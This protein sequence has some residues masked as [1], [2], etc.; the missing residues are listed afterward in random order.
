VPVKRC[1]ANS[2]GGIDGT[3]KGSKV[4][5]IAT[6]CSRGT[7]LID[8]NDYPC[9]VTYFKTIGLGGAG[10][11]VPTPDQEVGLCDTSNSGCTE[12]IDPVSQFSAN[13]VYNPGYQLIDN[14]Y[15]GWTGSK[16]EI[17]LE[18]NKL[19]IFGTESDNGSNTGEVKLTPSSGVK[20]LLNNN[21]LGTSTP[22]LAISTGANRH[23]LFASLGN[24][25]ATL[26][27]GASGKTIIVKEAVVDYQLASN[28]DKTS[29]NGLV[30]F[31]NGCILFN[32]RKVNGSEGLVS[33]TSG[34]DAYATLDG[35]APSL[36]NSGAPDSCNA[37]KLIKVRPNRVC[38]KWLDCLTY[39]QDPTTNEKTC[40]AVGE[41]N[42]LNDKN[43]CANFMDTVGASSTR[44]FDA[45]RDKDATGYSLIDKYYF[46]Q[47]KEVGLNSGAHYD[48]EDSVPTLSCQRVSG[49]APCSF[50]K[51][52]AADSLVREPE[53]APTD[54]PAHGKSYLKVPAGY[55][56]SP[57]A[58]DSPIAL[59]KDTNYYINYLVNTKNSGLASVLEIRGSVSA[60]FETSVVLGTATTSAN[61]GWK[62]VIQKFN[63]VSTPF[64]KI[65]LKADKN[66]N[67]GYVYFDDINIE[68][69]L[70][71]GENEYLA[72]E[73]RL[74]PDTESLT[75]LSKNNNVISD[76]LYG[77][78]LEHDSSN[79]DVCLLWYPVD[80][81]SSAKSRQS[82]L[83]YTGKFP[84]N[85]CTELN[86]NFDLVEKRVAQRVFAAGNEDGD[87]VVCFYGS[88][89]DVNL[90]SPNGEYCN[91]HHGNS[92]NGEEGKEDHVSYQINASQIK[93][94][95]Q[96]E[97]SSDF[98]YF[99]VYD[100]GWS[101]TSYICMPLKKN[102]LLQVNQEDIVID[103]GN[104]PPVKYPVYYSGWFV[105]NGFSKNGKTQPLEACPKEY[106]EYA[107]DE[108]KNGEPLV[109]VYD[110]I[111]QPAD[112]N[113][114]KLI[115][116]SDTDKVFRLSC[117]R[118]TQVVDS[119]G[120]NKA[121]TNRISS[122]S[123]FATQTPPFF[124]T[125]SNDFYG[126]SP[127]NLSRYG[128]NREET[129]FGAAVWP[130]DFDLLS[131][132]PIK[133]R[134]QYS[135]KNNEEIFAGRPYGCLQTSGQ[136][137]QSI[138]YCSLDPNVFCLLG[139]AT[140]TDYVSKNT[141]ADGRFGV[142]APV[143]SP[144]SNY[145]KS[146]LTYK[147]ILRTLFLKTYNAFTY[148][149]DQ[150]SY[151]PTTDGTYKDYTTPEIPFLDPCGSV[152]DRNSNNLTSFCAIRPTIKN[153][154][155]KFASGQTISGTNSFYIPAKGV[156]KLEFNTIVDPEQ[157]P[158]KE[159]RIDWDFNG[160][161]LNPIQVITGQDHHPSP[162]NPH[163]FYHYYKSTG[164][165]TIRVTVY[166]N[167]G[168][169][170]TC[171]ETQGGEGI[172]YPPID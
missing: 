65:Y 121:W 151:V 166:D 10:N 45:K 18:P 88:N 171:M 115:S 37:N 128:R 15:E 106:C 25:K 120:E 38:A 136:G 73:C 145:L 23:F 118:F 60:D 16:Q 24:T 143:W 40:Y 116:G 52:I 32:E 11:H 49:T 123:V 48:F 87:E 105:Y 33:L 131:S 152:T 112:E 53:G 20:P 1:D 99:L 35:Q 134:D 28:I 6:D 153:L 108:S 157:Q 96:S 83:G 119:N 72:K 168:K 164:N 63:T 82:S 161:D 147:N 129:P 43:E 122:N 81:I 29:C 135:K 150:Q 165:K 46:G 61:N 39:I 125:D 17:K 85:Y 94:W 5:S 117:N 113:N 126:A 7:C 111:S 71:V 163:V 57:Q 162:D 84:L 146:D 36:C 78:C 58:K 90:S 98:D 167:W 172:C 4:C 77:Y 127:Y 93:K 130:D 59:V 137:C 156:Y 21:T 139:N 56:F 62:R 26:A 132:E 149:W 110:H 159:I 51:N 27:G 31:D 124:V 91:I 64:V 14:Q 47:I 19:Y 170:G 160:T 141:C 8:N 69:V 41:C 55:I 133:F 154:T 75:C 86:G 22:S 95:C 9:S 169:Y 79:P 107:F 66:D 101:S 97:K 103:K 144:N 54:Y 142:C 70:Q 67:R 12:Y 140:S 158:L 2:S 104:D 92:P 100:R 155:L 148:D 80:W 50:A 114:L 102:H 74:Y 42:R 89:G 109:K 44:Q 13:L 34:W 138:G 68:P 3:E 30:K 76:G